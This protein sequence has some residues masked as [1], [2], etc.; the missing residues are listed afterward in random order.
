MMILLLLVHSNINENKNNEID[1]LL[2]NVLDKQTLDI[3]Q[4]FR[5]VIETTFSSLGEDSA[6]QEHV[7]RDLPVIY[8][9]QTA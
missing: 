4:T 3:I 2:L 8:Y 5:G 1:L 6:V 7:L 9:C